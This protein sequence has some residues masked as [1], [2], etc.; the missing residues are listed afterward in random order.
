MS[1]TTPLAGYCHQLGTQQI[2]T[3]RI[4]II[5]VIFVAATS[6]FL[7][8]CGGKDTT[9]LCPSIETVELEDAGIF[10]MPWEKH[11]VF[12]LYEVAG[13]EAT[14]IKFNFQP[15]SAPASASLSITGRDEKIPHHGKMT[16]IFDGKVISNGQP[17]GT[18]SV[19]GLNSGEIA[20]YVELAEEHYRFGYDLGITHVYDEKKYPDL[21]MIRVFVLDGT[22]SLFDKDAV[23]N[24]TI[25]EVL[26]TPKVFDGKSVTL[27]G[28]LHNSMKLLPIGSQ[29][30]PLVLWVQD[31]GLSDKRIWESS[32]EGKDVTLS[33]VI[34]NNWRPRIT[35]YKS[36]VEMQ[37]KE[38]CWGNDLDPAKPED[39]VRS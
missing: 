10:D 26:D 13:S 19:E 21:L 18:K 25:E 36:I 6:L 7:V 8:A 16:L 33:G 32:C 39:K 37:T 31:P 2:K 14:C 20:V 1:T 27:S 12:R 22:D 15:Q 9:I 17:V 30:T 11:A 34:D 24:T 38:I 3:P 23:I 28:N 35:V 29:D 4:Y 5:R